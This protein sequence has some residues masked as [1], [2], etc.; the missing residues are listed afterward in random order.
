MP[1]SVRPQTPA[2]RRENTTYVPPGPSEVDPFEADGVGAPSNFRPRSS[3]AEVQEREFARQR[4]I[5]ANN[6]PFAPLIWIIALAIVAGAAY[7]LFI[8]P[9]S[10]VPPATTVPS[11]QTSQ[12]PA[13]TTTTPPAAPQ[14]SGG[15]AK[16]STDAG[17]NKPAT[18]APKAN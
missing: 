10:N 9:G 5:G 14:S 6:S 8:S 13:V 3:D 7:Y 12:A 1:N 16:P 18:N 2:G 17:A 15:T 11:A 4:Q